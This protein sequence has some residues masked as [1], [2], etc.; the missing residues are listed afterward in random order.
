MN[1]RWC[2]LQQH[3][4]G[5]ISGG[6]L[7]VL[8]LASPGAEQGQEEINKVILFLM[9]SRHNEQQVLPSS[10]KMLGNPCILQTEVTNWL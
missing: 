1:L 3:R 9:Y 4:I 10:L 5:A 6:I 8:V 7:Q 2:D